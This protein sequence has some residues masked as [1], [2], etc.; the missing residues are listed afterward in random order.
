MQCPK[1]KGQSNKQK[2]TQKTK[3]RATRTPLKHE[4]NSGAPEGLAVLPPHVAPISNTQTCIVL[5]YLAY[6]DR[7]T[8]KST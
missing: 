6:V 5:L 2:D 1:E 4:V 8:L 7:F 3:D